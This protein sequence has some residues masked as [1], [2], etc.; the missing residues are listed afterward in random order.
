MRLDK[1]VKTAV[2]ALEDI[3]GRD[4]VVLDV[5]RIRITSYNVCYTKLL[6]TGLRCVRVLA[7]GKGGRNGPERHTT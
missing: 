7:T 6:R 5:K 1:L 2:A 3:K 4:I